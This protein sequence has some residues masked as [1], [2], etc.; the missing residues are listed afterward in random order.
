MDKI[1]N[2]F[3]ME[4]DLEHNNKI[5]QY[6]IENTFDNLWRHWQNAATRD[7]TGDL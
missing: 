4:Y 6:K 5:D 2:I 3:I 7:R 1:F